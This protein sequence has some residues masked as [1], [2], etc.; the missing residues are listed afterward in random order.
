[1]KAVK[2]V[3]KRDLIVADVNKPATDG[4][5]V[6]IKIVNCGICG[7]DIHFWNEGVGAAGYQELILG[8]E[9]DG[10]VE[11]AGSRKDLKQGDRVTVIPMNPCGECPTC[12]KGLLNLCENTYK[13]P[14]PGQNGP[15]GYAEYILARPDMVR[16]LPESISDLEGAMIEPATVGLHAVKE[17]GVKRGDRVLIVGGGTIGLICAAWARI[18]GASFVAITE[19]NEKRAAKA[20]EMGDANEVFDAADKSL[21]S[22]VKKAAGGGVDV[23]IDASASDAGI[24]S[25]LGMLRP[26]G[27]LVLA[28]ISFAPQSLLTLVATMKEIAIRPSYAYLPGDFDSAIDSMARGILKTER[29]ISRII[30]MSEVQETFERLDSRTSDD[31]KIVIG[32]SS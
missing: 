2:L 1:L 32:I 25:A 22:N 16:R 21:K 12:R 26:K 9:L 30:G 27:T 4:V 19:A 15:G 18:Q 13:R 23:A 3:G 8:H 14:Q 28:G 6:L 17:A 10:I 24:N 31:V 7:S 29:F 5:N 11:D 20:R